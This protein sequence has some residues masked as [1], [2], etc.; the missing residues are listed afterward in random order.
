M[1]SK[2]LR[3]KIIISSTLSSDD[4]DDDE[5]LVGLSTD[6]IDN[7]LVRLGDEKLKQLKSHFPNLPTENVL[8]MR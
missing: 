2:K 6:N 1:S 8:S 5:D 4:C 7:I 3:G